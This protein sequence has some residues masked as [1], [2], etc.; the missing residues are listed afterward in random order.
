MSREVKQIEKEV[1]K[2]PHVTAHAHR[3]GGREFRLGSAEVGHVHDGGIVDIPFPRAVHDALLEE[4]LAER[5]RW[6]PDSGWTTFRVRHDN[7]LPQALWL[8]RISYL[9]YALKK[10]DAPQEFF[11]REAASLKLSERFRSLLA[12]FVPQH[13]Q[14]QME[15]RQ[16]IAGFQ[17]SA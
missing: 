16:G 14:L 4:G 15:A 11:E 10:A 13:P 12:P 3:F 5:H 9:R 8:L 1:L 7:K 2:W 6:V 17:R